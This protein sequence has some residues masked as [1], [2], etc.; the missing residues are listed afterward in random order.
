MIDADACYK[1]L[2]A[3][4]DRFDGLFYVGV[5]TTGVYCR[6]ICPARTPGRAR[7]DFFDSAAAAES[8]GFRACFR[9]RPELAP[10]VSSVDQIPRLVRAA[11]AKIDAGALNDGS[12]EA[13]ARS[14]GVSGRHLRRAMESELGVSPVA[15]AQ[16]R[17][18]ALARS[19]LRDS[20]MPVTE[21]AFAAGFSSI[22]R[23]NAAFRAAL[24][25]AP[26]ALRRARAKEGDDGISLRL[27]H[28]PTLDFS[29]MLAFLRHRAIAGVEV[30]DDLS[31][32][33]TVSLGGSVGWARVT[34]EG[35]RNALRVRVSRALAPRLMEL[36][37][38]LRG[39][40]DLD[41]RPDVIDA[42]L[43]QD[44]TLRPCV[45]ARAG[46]RVPGAFDGFEMAVRAVLGQQVSVK[47]A[48]TLSGRVAERFG[49]EVSTEIPGLTRLFP[50]AE[51]LAAADVSALRAL[52]ITEA[53][54]RAI[55]GLAKAV[56]AGEIELARG[57]DPE[58]VMDSLVKLDGF[59]PWTASYVAMRALG[60][61]DAF[62]AHDL[63]VQ[64]ALGVSTAR[65]AE[66]LGARWSPWRAYAV[67]HL[68]NGV[69]Q[70]EKR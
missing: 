38:R 52:G 67:M 36:V 69:S 11:T 29:A 4:D 44:P 47:A 10:G 60:W 43:S 57:A 24:G 27:D 5:K 51:V 1:A 18:L 56:A 53:R 37:S 12:L 26:S 64:K 42:H 19:L 54:A 31:Y 39:L 6:P 65:E 32:G 61:P 28:R 34:R 68:W 62:V 30:I 15:L 55:M 49:A 16:S 45:Q 63:A 17:R 9:C 14:L 50:R 59:G 33:R 7:C 20:A 21:V 58:R 46:M 22:R 66:A 48:T 23:F 3:R 13:L 40:F 25:R 8:Q 2:C 70:G 41:A 35:A